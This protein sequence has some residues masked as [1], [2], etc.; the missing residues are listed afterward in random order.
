VTIKW[1]NQQIVLLEI[2]LQHK[3]QTLLTKTLNYYNKTP[4][5]VKNG[6]ATI[7]LLHIEL[8]H[9][10]PFFIKVTNDY[11]KK[12]YMK[13]RNVKAKKE[14]NVKGPRPRGSDRS[15]P[16]DRSPDGKHF[17]FLCYS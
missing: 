16:L 10:T 9:K 11:N 8:Q 5:F 2:D 14:M 6:K 13:A 7:N 3:S 17:P 12:Q 4:Y 15:F 1:L